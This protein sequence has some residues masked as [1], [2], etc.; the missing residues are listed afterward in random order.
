M[1]ATDLIA[2]SENPYVRTWP[3]GWLFRLEKFLEIRVVSRPWQA[4]IVVDHEMATPAVRIQFC[5][6]HDQQGSLYS[7]SEFDQFT[8]QMAVA[9]KGLHFLTQLKQNP[10]CPGQALV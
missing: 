10:S 8:A 7:I 5:G 9:V 1:I 4:L 6:M 3:R 2:G